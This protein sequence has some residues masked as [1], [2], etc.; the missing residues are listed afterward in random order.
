MFYVTN[1]YDQAYKVSEAGY[2]G[3]EGYKKADGTVIGSSTYDVFGKT[4]YDITMES[5][6]ALGF[7]TNNPESANF[8]EDAILGKVILRFAPLDRFGFVE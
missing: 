5:M 2:A 8:S 1:R 4:M 6:S 7:P 3:Q